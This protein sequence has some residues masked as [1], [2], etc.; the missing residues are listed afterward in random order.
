VAVEQLA[1]GRL[2]LGFEL[3]APIA[4][5]LSGIPSAAQYSRWFKSLRFHAS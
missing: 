1:L 4:E 5:S 2:W 3:R